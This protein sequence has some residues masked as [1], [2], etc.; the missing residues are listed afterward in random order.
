[1]HVIS[2]EPGADDVG[3]ARRLK[4]LDGR[5]IEPDAFLEDAR[6]MAH[7]MGQNGA[8][9]VGHLYGSELHA[10]LAFSGDAPMRSAAVI[11]AMTDSAISAGLCAPMASPMGA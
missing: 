8:F 11:S 10:A 9:G 1:M 2:F 3:D 6:P 7:R 5:G 4:A